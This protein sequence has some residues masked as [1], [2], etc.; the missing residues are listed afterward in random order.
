MRSHQFCFRSIEIGP[1]TA[2]G[3]P[4]VGIHS[5]CATARLLPGHAGITAKDVQVGRPFSHVTL[6]NCFNSPASGGREEKHPLG[7]MVSVGRT[8]RL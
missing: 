5:C 1:K 8:N 3:V 6:T 2:E 7:D 4:T